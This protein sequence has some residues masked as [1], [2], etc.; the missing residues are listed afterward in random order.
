MP[1]YTFSA[2]V[3]V[4]PPTNVQS[5]PSADFHEEK[6]S[7]DRSSFIQYGAEPSAAIQLVGPPS[8]ER[9]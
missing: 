9:Y 4:V 3:I 1:I 7:P 8:D 5:V 6:R 2:I